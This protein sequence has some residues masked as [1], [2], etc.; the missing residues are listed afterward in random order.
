MQQQLKEL[1]IVTKMNYNNI[2]AIKRRLAE[3]DRRQARIEVSVNKILVTVTDLKHAI[4]KSNNVSTEVISAPATTIEMPKGF[5]APEF[6]MESL[7]QLITLNRNLKDG[8]FRTFLVRFFIKNFLR[9]IRLSKSRK[10]IKFD[11]LI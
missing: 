8:E 4:N 1:R 5:K 6:P 7:P 2:G 10:S 11:R 3:M 9:F